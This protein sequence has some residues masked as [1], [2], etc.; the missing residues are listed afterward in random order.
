MLT[1]TPFTWPVSF[2]CVTALDNSLLPNTYNLTIS[3]APLTA[4]NQAVI[5]LRK[6][7]EFVNNFVQ[8]SILIS[9]TSPLLPALINSDTNT[10]HLPGEPY[11]YL[12]ASV[13]YRKLSFISSNYLT[14]SSLTIDSTIGDNIQYNIIS[15]DG[16]YNEILSNP[17]SWWNLDS[18]NTN[19]MREF[20]SWADVNI[21][22]I[23]PFRPTIIQ[24]GKHEGNPSR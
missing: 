6:I 1:N 18:L 14:I 2:S 12:L 17:D 22:Q 5:G 20:P 16:A 21:A 15:S 11:D 10:V 13:L 19:S 8:H 7:K 3:I 24:G 23:Q 9:E 4:N